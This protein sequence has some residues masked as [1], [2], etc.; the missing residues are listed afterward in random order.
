MYVGSDYSTSVLSDF[1][2]A[3]WNK[4]PIV[5]CA[6][7]M[8]GLSLVSS[9]TVLGYKLNGA[10]A[11]C[12]VSVFVCVLCVCHTTHDTQASGGGR[13]LCRSGSPTHLSQSIY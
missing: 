12:C 4:G 9:A 10:G 5:G 3:I 2:T 6:A 13:C 1:M 7:L 11:L 8:Q